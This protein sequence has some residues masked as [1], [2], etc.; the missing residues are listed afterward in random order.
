VTPLAPSRNIAARMGRWS[1][2]HWKTAT[3]GWL[4]FVLAAFAIGNALGTKQIDTDKSGNGESG[5]VTAVLA[6]EFKQSAQETVLVQSPSRTVGD[7]SFRATVR[8]V[9]TRL[10][11][12]PYVRDI[13]SPYVAGN[14]GQISSDR[15]SA[16]VQFKLRG[17]D[18]DASE[19]D[20]V[21]VE[22]A[23]AALDK[24][25]PGYTIGEFGD[26]SA[27]KAL[28]DAV[29]KDFAKAGILSIPVTLI[30]LVVAFGA[31]IAAGLPILLALTGVFATLGLLAIPSRL[32]PMDQDAA[33]IVLLIGL[34]VGVD[35]SLFYLKRERE[36]R[37]RG[38]GPRAALDAAAAT[39]GRSVLISGLTV[40]I[41]MAGM[42]FTG[43]KSF[44]SFGL[45]TMMVVAV[46]VLG[47]LTVLPA[48]LARAG[49]KIHRGRIPFVHRLARRG[50]REPRVWGAI[51]DR[52]LRRPVVSAAL[53]AG[54]LLALAA[55]ALHLHTNQPGIDT[56]PKSLSV[57][58]TYDRLEKAFP[59]EQ[60]PALVMVKTDDVA[61][62]AATKAIKALERQAL[63]TGEFN[64]PTTVDTNARG[65][66]AVIA[67][68]INGNGTDAASSHAVRTLRDDIV[69][70]TVGKLPNSDVGV[71]GFTAESDDFNTQM[72]HAA[73]YVFGFVLAFAFIL[74]LLSFRSIVIAV[75]AV[76]LNLLSVAASYGLL[77]LVFQD[78]WGKGLLGFSETGGV[79]A[80]LPIL[81][82]VILFGLSMDYHVFIL[83]RVR[84]AFDRGMTTDE[85]VAHGI[86]TTASVVTSAALVMVGVFSIFATLQ[87]MFLKQFGVGLAA[88]VLIDATI[89]RAVLLPAT[90]K[91]LGD[92]N[93]YLP[94]WLEWLPQVKHET[95]APA[96]PEAAPARLAA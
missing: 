11:K 56:F 23:V 39:S 81:L 14:E 62:P 83:S 77:V 65:T 80:F 28:N 9:E 47:S 43:D 40:M 13:R 2:N 61:S 29:G 94:R 10:A 93:W 48:L 33:V 78:G 25:H 63:A 19:R 52:V 6:D 87:F 58:K 21:H 60:V 20:V 24:A 42:F 49:D 72:K 59:G 67:L 16:I 71:G 45:A 75:K 5:H 38:A 86:K 91:L 18:A 37:D 4:A 76:V 36:E 26:A 15:R 7:P 54:V 55:P 35:Y 96:Q 31:L 89:V 27:D 1:A 64:G 85:A 53:A 95:E 46:A 66:V 32:I 50:G 82:F 8:D 57:M 22:A 68:P 73:P 79:V 51:L 41:A 88:A 74:L 92:W 44:K 84:E 12:L 69:P 34:A 17:T 90:M 70:A 30:V 3:F